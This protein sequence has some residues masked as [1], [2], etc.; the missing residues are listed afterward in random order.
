M[1][2]TH[3]LATMVQ[4]Y[5]ASRASLDAVRQWL[6]LHAQDIMDAGDPRLDA[7]DGEL[8]LLISEMDRGDIDE[9]EVR[10]GLTRF[11]SEH[12]LTASDAPTSV[13]PLRSAS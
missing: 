9:D 6:V 12:R 4:A 5:L 8:W 10:A 1:S 3:E 7:L 13:P 2:L 11:V